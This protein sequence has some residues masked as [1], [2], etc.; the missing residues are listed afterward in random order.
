MPNQLVTTRHIGPVLT[1]NVQMSLYDSNLAAFLST[2]Q[3]PPTHCFHPCISLEL[4]DN[5]ISG[6]QY[7]HS[8][9][10]VHRDL[11]PAN[12]FLAL[13]NDRYPPAGSIDLSSCHTCLAKDCV[14][15][16]PRIGDFGLVAAVGDSSEKPVG[17]EFYRPPNGGKINE[18][19]DVFALGVVTFEMLN[20]FGT[21]MER[22]DALN[23]LRRGDISGD[24]GEGILGLIGGMVAVNEEERWDCEMVRGTIKK[25]VRGMKRE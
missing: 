5:I 14:H 22:I 3:T 6:V 15:V 10:V 9:G 20:Y 25:I 13:S 24:L 12:I 8:K 4:L 23:K 1:L 16:T 19:L 17:T 18:K 7:L 11:K 2:E 21:K